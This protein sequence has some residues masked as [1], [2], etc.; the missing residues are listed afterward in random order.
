M[1]SKCPSV[2]LKL[3]TDCKAEYET[4]KWHLQAIFKIDS[5]E[6]Q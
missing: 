2:L 1:Y 3:I 6:D 4:F 5:F